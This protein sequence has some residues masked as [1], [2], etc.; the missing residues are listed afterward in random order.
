M[1]AYGYHM[2]HA[3]VCI[4]FAAVV[5]VASWQGL[6]ARCATTPLGTHMQLRFLSLL[7][8]QAAAAAAVVQVA[9]W[10][11]LMAR[12]ATTTMGTPAPSMSAW[13]ML[14]WFKWH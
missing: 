3:C 11:G 2:L 9:S 8:L 1:S 13:G 6:M 12:C 14:R 10:Q 4:G 5:Q 7:L